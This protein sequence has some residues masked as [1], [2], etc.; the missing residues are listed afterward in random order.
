MTKIDTQ[1]MFDTASPNL[2]VSTTDEEGGGAEIQDNGMYE[3]TVNVYE[4]T[5]NKSI[6][7]SR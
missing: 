2:I 1:D 6:N 4:F 5:V 3:F 7:Q